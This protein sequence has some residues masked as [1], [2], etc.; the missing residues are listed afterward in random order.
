VDREI[1]LETVEAEPV[2]TAAEQRVSQG[3]LEGIEAEI[4]TAEPVAAE[5]PPAEVVATR[6]DEP[7]PSPLLPDRLGPIRTQRGSQPGGQR[8]R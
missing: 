8:R 7:K 5:R 3:L 6:V 4:I 1:P 2:E